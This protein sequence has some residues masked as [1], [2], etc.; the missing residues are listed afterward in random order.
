VTVE[1]GMLVSAGTKL[2]KETKLRHVSSAMAVSA[3]A[4][5]V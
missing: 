3:A 1:E 5:G 2:V 4:A